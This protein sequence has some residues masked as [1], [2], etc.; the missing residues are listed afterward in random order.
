MR[1][2]EEEGSRGP[3]ATPSLL[4]QTSSQTVGPFFHFGLLR[5]GGNVLAGPSARGER[6]ILLGRVTDGIGEPVPDA[7][8][9]IWQPDARGIFAHPA[10]PLSDQADPEFRGFGRAGTDVEGV[11]RFETVKPG[12]V[13]RPPDEASAPHANLHVFARG[14]LIHLMTR[15]YFEDEPANGGD[16]LLSALPE[17]K[18]TRLLARA[19]PG[20]GVPRTYRFDVCLQGELETPFFEP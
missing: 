10:D 14:M 20:E 3:D 2:R 5:E 17:E 7:L 12:A 1:R 15:I 8:L 18:R 4:P 6:I 13:A 16:P 19:E 11:Y 9:E